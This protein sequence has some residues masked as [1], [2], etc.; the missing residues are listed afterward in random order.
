MHIVCGIVYKVNPNN[1]K[2]YSGLLMLFY[3]F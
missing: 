2:N 1:L 3:L